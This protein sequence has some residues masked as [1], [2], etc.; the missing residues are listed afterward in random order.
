V[1]TA[2]AKSLAANPPP[3]RAEIQADGERRRRMPRAERERQMM[4]VAEECFAE[5]GY[6][7]ASMDEIAERVGVSKPM[8]YEYFGSKE[9]LLVACLRRVRTQLRTAVAEATDEAPDVEEALRRSL[10]AFFA[11]AHEHRRSWHVLLRT[12]ASVVGPAAATEIESARQEQ[13]KHI[14][15][16]AAHLPGADPL[17]AEAAAEMIVGAC[18]RLSVWYVQHEQITT[19]QA[20]DYAMR[21]V[22]R[23]LR[24]SVIHEA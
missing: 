13:T 11:F 20:A 1:T 14:A 23:G 22:W 12:E 18:E 24:D 16:I 8:I 10:L 3:S 9:G 2:N 5:R 6:L 7:A 21:L 15:R 4:A 19:Q 17:A